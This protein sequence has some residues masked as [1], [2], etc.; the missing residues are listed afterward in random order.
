MR[1]YNYLNESSEKIDNMIEMIKENCK[2]F[3]NDVKKQSRLDLLFSGRGSSDVFIERKIRK[4]RK[5]LDTPLKLQ[6]IVDDLFNKFY[7]VKPRSSSIFCYVDDLKTTAYGTPF[8]IFPIGSYKLLWSPEVNDLYDKISGQG[9]RFYVAYLRNPNPR[10]VWAGM[11]EEIKDNDFNNDFGRFKEYLES[12]QVENDFKEY[13]LPIIRSYKMI[14]ASQLNEP[15]TANEIMLM[16]EGYYGIKN[17]FFEKNAEKIYLE[18]G[19]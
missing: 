14:D 2:P 7:G 10:M 4:D 18:L 12:G 6:N 13:I 19:I 17:R 3:L 1:L 11:S 9:W 15:T 5:P 16:G 8:I